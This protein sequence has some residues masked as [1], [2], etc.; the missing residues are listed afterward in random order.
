MVNVREKTLTKRKYSSI[1]LCSMYFKNYNLPQPLTKLKTTGP[2]C[3]PHF[4]TSVNLIHLLLLLLI[5]ENSNVK[6]VEMKCSAHCYVRQ[7]MRTMKN[8]KP[9]VHFLDDDNFDG[10]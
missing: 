8:S 10:F 6:N 3:Y 2:K 5:R 1:P 4:L 9:H 7:T